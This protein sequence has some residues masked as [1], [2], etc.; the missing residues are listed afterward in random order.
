MPQADIFVAR[1]AVR[2]VRTDDVEACNPAA[3]AA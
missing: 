1:S 3:I 2:A